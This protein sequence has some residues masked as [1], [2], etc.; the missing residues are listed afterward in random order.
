MVIMWP[1]ELD[2]RPIAHSMN[3]RRTSGALHDWQQTEKSGVNCRKSHNKRLKRR[4]PKS[5]KLL[6]SPAAEV[7]QPH[8]GL[9]V[10]RAAAF[11]RSECA[12]NPR[13]RLLPPPLRLLRRP[14]LACKP[15]NCVGST[16]IYRD[17]KNFKVVAGRTYKC[18]FLETNRT[19]GSSIQP[20]RM[21]ASG[22]TR[23][24]D[25][26]EFFEYIKSIRVHDYFF[27]FRFTCPRI[28]FL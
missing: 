11:S 10:G 23:P 20:Q 15:T 17:G 28:T 2:R 8:R 21:F 14:E 12:V 13:S 7:G 22:A 9:R 25:N 18:E 16:W 3:L 5:I 6:C 4:A 19:G 27:G 1:T 26:R 24:L